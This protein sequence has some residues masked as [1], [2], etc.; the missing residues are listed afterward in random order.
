MKAAVAIK[1]LPKTKPEPKPKRIPVNRY[2]VHGVNFV[3][4]LFG[5]FLEIGV[6][7]GR[8][9]AKLQ[10]PITQWNKAKR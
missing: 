5:F 1:S 7:V 8:I 3:C 4:G 9:S 2:A 6:D 10:E